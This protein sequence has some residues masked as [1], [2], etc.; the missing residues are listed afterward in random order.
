MTLR[1]FI[2]MAYGE[3]NGNKA[4]GTKPVSNIGW[5]RS[6]WSFHPACGPPADNAFT[7]PRGVPGVFRERRLR[8][9]LRSTP[10]PCL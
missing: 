4:D 9:S 7:P 3:L 5:P 10:G 1:C 2:D 8:V 6:D